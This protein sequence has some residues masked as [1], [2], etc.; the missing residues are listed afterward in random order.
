MACNARWPVCVS[1]ALALC[2]GFPG[3]MRAAEN[4]FSAIRGSY[5]TTTDADL[6]RFTSARMSVEIVMTPGNAAELSALLADIYD[7]NSPNFQHWLAQGEFNAR[8]APDSAQTAAVAA[9]LKES[10]LTLEPTSSPFLLR[11][12][13]PSNLMESAFKTSLHSYRNSRGITY[14]ANAAEIQLPENLAAGVLGVVGLSNTARPRIHL[15]RPLK[16]T[17]SSSGCET[18][19]PT[20]AQLYDFANNQVN[21]PY[22]Y[23]AG[24][25]CSGLTPSQTNSMYGA[26]D[27]GPQAQGQGVNIAVFELS[28]YQHS[29]IDA[30]TDYFYG[31]GFK[32]P[33]VDVTVDGGPL[34]PKCPADD[35][36]P[37]AEQGYSGDIEVDADIEMQL[38]IAPAVKHLFVYNAPNDETGQTELDEYWR[39][40]GDDVADVISSSWGQCES[41]SGA[42]LLQAENLVFEQMALQGQSMFAAA[43]DTGAF[44]CLST[45][46]TTQLSVDDP[47]SQPWVTSVGGT[48]FDSFNPGENPYP[49]YPAGI[50][51]VWNVDNLCNETA[52]EGGHPGYFWCAETG[53]GGGGNSAFWGRPGY[54][55]GPGVT[56]RYS[57]YGNGSSNCA[58]APL[59]APCREVPDVSAN[60][61]PYTGYTE[62]CTGSAATPNSTCAEVPQ[63]PDGWFQIGGTSLSTPL[64]SGVVA[65]FDGFW[66]GRIG[67]ANPLLYLLLNVDAAGYFH[68]IT[69][70]GQSTNIN[71]FYPTTPGYDLATGMGTPRMGALITLDGN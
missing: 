35:Q 51:T 34:D 68:D 63:T 67:N 22:G 33:L 61:D 8:F 65:D 3:A 16:S 47:G 58:F 20:R 7:G 59:G 70:V 6:G 45:D 21:F 62:R 43:G 54:Q 9:Y 11:A 30:W 24:Q 31:P 50:E 69:G 40:A 53:A 44:D 18:P 46:D 25:D 5:K 42:A 32:A 56:N 14:Y 57:A 13:G 49:Y 55:R 37:A 28:A 52:N 36:C 39:I 19:Y 1:L 66:H 71:G 26:P 48:S 38:T 60:G 4:G 41:D 27:L 15:V 23:G 64:W 10:G 2:L 12:T 17:S 29:D